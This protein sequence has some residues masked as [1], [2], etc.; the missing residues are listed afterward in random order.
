MTTTEFKQKYP[1]YK[2][3]E[4]DELWDKM[5]E[6]LLETEDVLYADPNQIKVFHKP[7]ETEYGKISIE[8][9]STTRW[10]NSK[11]ELV[12]IG[13]PYYPKVGTPTESYRGVI[14]DFS[15]GEK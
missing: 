9:S 15:D 6:S 14:I 8:D 2:K 1:Q 11:G 7:I 5:T 12:R 10:L 3:L 13:E 4:G